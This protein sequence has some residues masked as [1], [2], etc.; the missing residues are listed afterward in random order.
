MTEDLASKYGVPFFRSKV[1]EANVV[2]VMLAE[3]AVI[4][5]EGNGGVIDPRVGLVRDSFV[6]MAL[7][8]DAMAERNM[9]LSQLVAELPHYAIQKSK[10][11][12][13]PEQVSDSFAALE[14]HFADAKADRL[15]GLRLDWPGKWL[16]VRGSNTEPI[17]RI[18]AEAPTAEEAK[19]LCD[20]AEAVL[21]R[22][23]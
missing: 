1:G 20:E 15:D 3:K 19:R 23:E 8:L 5:G 7:I 4:G 9:N 18:F 2:D 10:V 11:A 14:K 22:T 6:G 21:G 12:L 13:A 16:L 17:V